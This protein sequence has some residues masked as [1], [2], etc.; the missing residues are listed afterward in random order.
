MRYPTD[1]WVFHSIFGTSLNGM[2]LFRKWH[3]QTFWEH[4]TFNSLDGLIHLCNAW[5]PL[6]RAQSAITDA[7]DLIYQKMIK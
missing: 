3:N 4:Q 2:G 7:G 1:R 6:F 5:I